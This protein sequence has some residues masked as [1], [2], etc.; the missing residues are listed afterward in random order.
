MEYLMSEEFFQNFSTV[1]SNTITWKRWL[2]QFTRFNNPKLNFSVAERSERKLGKVLSA[3][4]LH[5]STASRK[6]PQPGDAATRHSWCQ[7]KIPQPTVFT[8]QD[9]LLHET[10]LLSLTSVGVTLVNAHST[11][12]P[13][14]NSCWAW[15]AN[16]LPSTQVWRPLCL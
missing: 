12:S 1:L 5:C 7:H 3:P 10:H 9:P 15:T 16:H 4:L 6:I 13:V 8:L 2:N 11:S 14:M